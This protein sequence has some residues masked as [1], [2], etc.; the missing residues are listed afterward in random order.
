MAYATK[1][2]NIIG[3]LCKE[4]VTYATAVALAGATD[5]VQ[6]WFADRQGIPATLKYTF[7]GETGAAPGNLGEIRN[8][9]PFGATVS[10]DIPFFFKGGGAAYSAAIFCLFHKLLKASGLDAAGSFVA[11]SEKWTFTPTLDVTIPTSLTL[12]IYTDGEKIPLTGVM[13]NWKFAGDGTG[14]VKH[15]FSLMG[16]KGT[17]ADSASSAPAGFTI[18]LASVVP[19]SSAGSTLAIGSYA[20][21]IG[22][23]SFDFDLGRSLQERPGLEAADGH[24]G[25]VHQG[26][27]PRF[28]CVIEKTAL[29]TT[30]FHAVGGLDPYKLFESGNSFALSLQHPGVQYNRWKM[31]F[32]QAQMIAAVTRQASNG[33]AA[34]KLDFMPYVSTPV[35]NDDISYVA[36]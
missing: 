1:L 23:K 8:A 31:S 15:T 11:S 14:L 4:E 21:A 22:L 29:A 30:P 12:E 17:V 28:S 18:P 20:T 34:M 24:L 6:P 36:D 32:P 19:P 7:S 35:A 13:C 16:I 33:V 25:Y 3:I 26:R 10:V 9:V 27:K 5:A 2:V